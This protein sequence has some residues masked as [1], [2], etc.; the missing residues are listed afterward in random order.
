M[1]VRLN[2]AHYPVTALG[3]GTRVGIWLQGCSLG[4]RGCLSLDTW[5]S[6]PE[7]EVEV[8]NVIDWCRRT[9]DGPL[10]GVT[11]SGGEPFEQPE[12]LRHLAEAF[13]RWR[14]ERGTPCD[15]LCYTGLTAR[16]LRRDHAD[17]LGLF[18]AV[19]PE[20]FLESRPEGAIWRGS[21]NQPLLALTALGQERYGHLA[22]YR[23]ERPPFQ[24][25]VTDDEIWYVGVPRRG[26]LQR[27]EQAARD[28]GISQG[29][30][31]WRT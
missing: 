26:D 25:A 2:K 8:D 27:L 22:A 17:L 23:P 13:H 7:H 11:F 15:L 16:H 19:I 28:A 6:S 4:C 21:D 9:V 24:V 1:K 12:A 18:D 14:D 31:S 30:P 3:H 20:P 10:D 5:V 29:T